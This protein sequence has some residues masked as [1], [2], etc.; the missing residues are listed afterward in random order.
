MFVNGCYPYVTQVDEGK[1]PYINV[2]FI[3]WGK[4]IILI[5]LS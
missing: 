2:C 4:Y 5:F 1:Q 3:D